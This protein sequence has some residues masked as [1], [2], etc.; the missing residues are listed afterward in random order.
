MKLRTPHAQLNP[1]LANTA[2]MIALHPSLK[3]QNVL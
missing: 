2:V 3:R 1:V